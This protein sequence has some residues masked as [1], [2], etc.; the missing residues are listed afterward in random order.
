MV[1]KGLWNY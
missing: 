1:M